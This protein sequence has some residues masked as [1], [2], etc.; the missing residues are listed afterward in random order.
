VEEVPAG[1]L[2]LIGGVDASI[3]KT[4]TLVSTDVEDD[5][6]IFRPIKHMT[7]S[8]LKVAIEP[9][10]PSELPKMLSGLRS[11]NKSYPLLSTKVEESGEHVIIGTGELYLDC[12]LHD[13]RKL[14]AEIEIKVSDPVTKFCETVLET[15]ALK[16]YA[17]TPNKKCGTAL[18][19][20]CLLTIWVQ[21]STDHDSRAIRT[22]H[23]G[24]YRDWTGQYE[25]DRERAWQIFRRKVQMGS[26]RISVHLGIW[27]R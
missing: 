21:E 25:D 24:R 18:L 5:L 8:V 10:A 14:F 15:S 9:I 13:L 17:D 26:P 16:C 2:V 7:Q 27:S 23:R 6:Y 22:W 19:Q 1:N 20:H 4:A 3:T 12:V 11:I